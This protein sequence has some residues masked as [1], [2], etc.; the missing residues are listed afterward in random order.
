ML[1]TDE[2]SHVTDAVIG[3]GQTMYFGI[4]NNAEFF[5]ILSSSLYSDQILAVVREV[6][7]NA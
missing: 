3:G 4:S 7:C 6:L 1:V 5:Q 2:Q